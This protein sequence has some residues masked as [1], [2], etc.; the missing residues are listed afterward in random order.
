MQEFKEGSVLA[1]GT[2]CRATPRRS[3]TGKGS[4]GSQN[5]CCTGVNYLY[6][7]ITFIKQ[8]HESEHGLWMQR[9]IR[10]FQIFNGYYSKFFCEV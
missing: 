2:G 6:F 4:G 3:P 5:T 7:I 1:S 10:T 8:V 9:L